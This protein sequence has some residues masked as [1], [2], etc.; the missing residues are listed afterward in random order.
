MLLALGQ[1]FEKPKYFEKNIRTG[2]QD[3]LALILGLFSTKHEALDKSLGLSFLI[4]ER[5]I[6]SV[7]LSDL[8]LL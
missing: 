4:C 8:V 6:F 7:A 5:R 2:S 3:T 1:H